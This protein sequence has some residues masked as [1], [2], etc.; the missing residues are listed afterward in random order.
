M[1][2]NYEESIRFQDF[3]NSLPTEV[4]PTLFSFDLENTKNIFSD[5]ELYNENKD[6][7]SRRA[8]HLYGGRLMFSTTTDTDNRFNEIRTNILDFYKSNYYKYKTLIATTN[9]VYNPIWNV[10]GTITEE[11]TRTPNLTTTSTDTTTTTASG[12]GTTTNS[13]S[14]KTTTTDNNTVTNSGQDSTQTN[15]LSSNEKTSNVAPFDAENF[16]KLSNETDKGNSDTT[17][18]TTHG[19]TVAENGDSTA[20]ITHGLTVENSNSANTTTE[21]SAGTTTTGNEKIVTTTTRSGNIGVTMT[22]ALIK[23]ERDVA[24]INIIDMFLEELF[25]NISFNIY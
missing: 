10:D 6:I 16:K 8:L 23:E 13:G 15:V 2:Y 17:A 1:L 3:Y 7:F 24:E 25:N 21:N 14:D 9:F 20:T 19:L 22:Q 18:T 12:T 5:L 4:Q 11:T